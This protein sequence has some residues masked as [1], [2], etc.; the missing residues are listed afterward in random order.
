M[1]IDDSKR[2]TATQRVRAFD[3]ISH[4]A[5]VGFGIVCAQDIDRWNILRAT[6]LAMQQ[7]VADLSQTP[8]VVLVDG[9]IAPP[10]TFPC[11][12][13]VHGDQRSYVIACASIM[14]KVLRDRLM[15]FYHH[16]SP[17]YAW[18]R[19][20]GYGTALHVARLKTFGPSFFHRKSF[21]PV[22]DALT[23]PP[24][25]AHVPESIDAAV[26]TSTVALAA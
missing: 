11:W 25:P 1:R 20:K 3:V 16:L 5:D 8:D 7:A 15:E 6:L 19:H 13:L 24:D 9:P 2:L 26:T 14:A 17:H 18:H 23:V 12:P 22:L 21:K 4:D 10:I